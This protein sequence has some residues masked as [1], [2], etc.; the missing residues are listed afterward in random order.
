MILNPHEA[1]PTQCIHLH[2]TPR[3]SLLLFSLIFAPLMGFLW[4]NINQLPTEGYC[5]N[6]SVA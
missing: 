5:K 4:Q 2:V 6:I 3:Q 1:P